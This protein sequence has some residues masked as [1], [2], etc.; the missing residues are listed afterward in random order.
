MPRSV[1]SALAATFLLTA[2]GIAHASSGQFDVAR[3]ADHGL[4][5]VGPNGSPV[6]TFISLTGRGTDGL[7]PLESCNERCRTDWPVVTVTERPQGSDALDDT[8]FATAQDGDARVAVYNAWPL[9]YFAGED[10]DA[11]PDG[12]AIHTYGGWW[13]L[14]SPEGEPIRTGVM[15]GAGD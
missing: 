13:A 1:I 10:G 12:H 9:F 3:H 6:Y 4:Y 7:P 14:L 11:T 15:P 5:L 2:P 8:L